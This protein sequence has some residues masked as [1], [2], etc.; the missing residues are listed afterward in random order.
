MSA[1]DVS[2][3]P[4]LTAIRQ[5]FGS[6]VVE[7]HAF[8]GDETVVILPTKLH[9]LMRFLRD[10]PRMQFNFLMDITAVDWPER[11]PRF[12]VVYHLYSL[13][14]NRRLRVKTRV[15]D[16]DTVD[17]VTDLWRGANWLEREVYDMFGIRFRHH[18]DLR[19]ILMYD[20]FE[21]HP[22]RKD[23]PLRQEQPRVPYRIAP[24]DPWRDP[25]IWNR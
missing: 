14:Y 21:G 11:H 18:P 4:V 9:E 1:R 2:H 24:R 3:S 6:A 20:E 8:R 15:D 5:K 17:S 19:R 22:L 23:Y 13:K 16:G 25:D 10:D 7:M 12:D